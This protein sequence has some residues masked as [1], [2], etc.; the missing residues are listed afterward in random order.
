MKS[1]HIDIKFLVIK[2]RVQNGQKSI[3]HIDANLMIVDPLTKGSPPKV[4]HKH[5]AHMSVI[6]LEDM[7]F[8]WEFVS[9]TC[10]WTS[11]FVM[12]I[13]DM[14]YDL[15]RHLQFIQSSVLFYFIFFGYE[16]FGL[17]I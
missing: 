11:T 13:L 4:C 8:Q 3:E 2:E 14:V 9:F 5:N 1:K 17:Y 7:Q 10:F 12:D 6:S 16:V 15:L